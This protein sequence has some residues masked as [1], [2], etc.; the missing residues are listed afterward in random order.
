MQVRM[1]IAAATFLLRRLHLG[2]E[3][4]AVSWPLNAAEHSQW[5]RELRMIQL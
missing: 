4:V 2:S 3:H 1:E 5:Y